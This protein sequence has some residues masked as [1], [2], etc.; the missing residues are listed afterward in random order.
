MEN[1]KSRLDDDEREIYE[2]LSKKIIKK[3]DSLKDKK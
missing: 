2:I 1:H 3:Q